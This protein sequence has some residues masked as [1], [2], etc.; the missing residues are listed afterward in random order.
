M[1]RG[2]GITNYVEAVSLALLVIGI[3]LL[4]ISPGR[5][6]V[7]TYTCINGELRSNTTCV[8]PQAVEV[9]NYVIGN[10]LISIN[11][12]QPEELVNGSVIAREI[13]LA[14]VIE[15]INYV[16]ETQVT[17]NIFNPTSKWVNLTLPGSCLL[18][19][20]ATV[21][22][23]GYVSITVF[24]G[25]KVIDYTPYTY[26]LF[27]TTQAND[28]INM[29]IKPAVPLSCP[30][31]HTILII[32]I[33]GT[34]TLRSNAFVRSIAHV[35]MNDVVNPYRAYALILLAISSMALAAS[36]ILGVKR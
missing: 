6:V 34:C 1:P 13:T 22:G 26:S 29:L 15:H 9:S 14:P 25:G 7:I 17:F 5:G 4:V 19:V 35:R 12:G 24:S 28:D 21:L 10:A 23:S 33:N 3:L 2:L 36:L 30:C 32:S 27:I 31:I 18:T 8:F 20:N 11:N 16:N